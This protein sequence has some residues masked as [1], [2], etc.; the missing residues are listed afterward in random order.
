MQSRKSWLMAF[1]GSRT[2]SAFPMSTL[3]PDGRPPLTRTSD[4]DDG[5]WLQRNWRAKDCQ[6]WASQ[7]CRCAHGGTGGTGTSSDEQWKLS[8]HGQWSQSVFSSQCSAVSGP[9]SFHPLHMFTVQNT[10]ASNLHVHRIFVCFFTPAHH[11]GASQTYKFLYL[12]LFL[13]QSPLPLS[14]ATSHSARNNFFFHHPPNN[15]TLRPL[16]GKSTVLALPDL[17]SA[18]FLFFA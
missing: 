2:L 3:W 8:G 9:S 13:P 18:R 12:F 1:F 16:S 15:R 5:R 11:R 4:S 14:P 10:L 7:D 17:E 6:C